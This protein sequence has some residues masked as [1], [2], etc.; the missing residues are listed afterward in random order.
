[1][2]IIKLIK[3][4]FA[5][6]IILGF[7]MIITQSYY[8]V[9]DENGN[10][11][12]NMQ[13]ILLMEQEQENKAVQNETIANEEVKIEDIS[14]SASKENI[15]EQNT[16]DEKKIKKITQ[17][18]KKDE[19]IINKTTQESNVKTKEVV[20]PEPK[21][22]VIQETK[23]DEDYAE[24]EV[25]VAEKKECTGENHLIGVGNT[26]KWFNTKSE[27]ENFYDKE[28]AKWGSMWENDEI[29]KE[30]YLKK[31]PSGY[32]VWSCPLCQK[33]TLNYYYR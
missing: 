15:Q 16:S 4:I 20:V 12:T 8:G 23:T 17:T 2:K 1:M 25:E 33:W 18:K 24:R 29:T 5:L 22:E 6:L 10:K 28:I 32:E 19:S 9:V 7:Y 30:E 13:E 26:G 21:K 27:A 14:V 11:I 31:C 3:A